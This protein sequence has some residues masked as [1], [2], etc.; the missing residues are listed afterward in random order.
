MD[1]P[2][3]TIWN[4]RLIT[5]LEDWYGV[6]YRYGGATKKGIDCSAF[7]CELMDDVYGVTLPRTSRDQYKAASQISKKSLEQGDL[8]FF[9]TRG[10][11]IS[12]VGVYLGNNKFVHASTSSG[13]MI[14]DLDENYFSKRFS[15]SGRIR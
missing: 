1:K 13:V 4:D 7:T 10:R 14:S 15:G 5:F 12:H 6:P 9:N 11:G 3:E 2:V 8:V